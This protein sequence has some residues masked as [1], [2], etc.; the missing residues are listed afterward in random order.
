[1]LRPGRQFYRRPTA[2]TALV[3]LLMAMVT[4]PTAVVLTV[5]ARAEVQTAEDQAALSKITVAYEAS[6]DAAPTKYLLVAKN[7]LY[8]YVTYRDGARLHK[9]A[10]AIGSPRFG[11]PIDMEAIAR[12]RRVV[13]DT[14]DSIL[15]WTA[16]HLAQNAEV[17]DGT[18]ACTIWADGHNHFEGGRKTTRRP[19]EVS[20]IASLPTL[21]G[22]GWPAF[23]LGGSS[24]RLISTDR[25]AL[26]HDLVCIEEQ[27]QAIRDGREKITLTTRSYLNPERNF[28]CERKHEASYDY[29]E[30]VTKYGKIR[31]AQ[32]YPVEISEFGYK[33]QGRPMTGEPSQ[34]NRIYLDADPTFPADIFSPDALIARYGDLLV[35]PEPGIPSSTEP[36]DDSSVRVAGRVLDGATREPIV[37]ALVRVAAPAIDMRH[38][39]VAVEQTLYE[40]RTGGDGLFELL[41]P[42]TEEMNDTSV[43]AMAPGYNTAAGT[44]RNGA[45]DP[46]L[47]NLPLDRSWRNL[48]SSL[49][50]L[51][52]PGL[53]VAGTVRDDQ[54]R[55]VPG[56]TVF[57]TLRTERSSGGIART[58]TD[59]QGRFEIFD[60]PLQKQP[61][62]WAVLSFTSATTRQ[63]NVTGLYDMTDEQRRSLEVTVHSGREITGVVHNAASHPAAGITVEAV[64]GWSIVIRET[65]TDRDGH[66]E[67]AGL[68]AG[69]LDVR[70]YDLANDQKAMLPITAGN[71]DREVTVRMQP[72]KLTD[73]VEPVTMLGM[74][75]VD[76][77]QELQEAYDAD[78]SEGVMIWDPGP[79]SGRLGIGELK[80]G[81]CIWMVGDKRITNLKEMVAEILQA[82]L[83]P[84][85]DGEARFRDPPARVRVVYSTRG[86]NNTQNL[87]LT[88]P[89]VAELGQLA[90]RLGIAVMGDNP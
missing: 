24:I 30:Q 90:D 78:D 45:D 70:A 52:S 88:T 61:D 53:Y 47:G 63:E 2:P 14:L 35:S 1:M 84:W 82:Q 44:F 40:T 19:D 3:I 34:I 32:W 6:R 50:I 46:L 73:P 54:G 39:R 77:T 66:F 33:H 41:V 75:V 80:K 68:P 17:Y 49:T 26:D 56:M 67:L 10:Y 69:P 25:F 29:A 74:Q 89:D 23:G 22:I 71:V 36:E 11:E 51:L 62:E 28:I 4:V 86:S 48:R 76:A 79:D 21:R 85:Q 20:G 37:G 9:A 18:Y 65:T 55:P 57:A 12:D 83:T 42:I 5:R 8:V 81:Y 31:D 43:D 60:Y 15:A 13:G 87:K 16:E 27:K 59:A 38:A 72:I 7:D 58:Q 64:A